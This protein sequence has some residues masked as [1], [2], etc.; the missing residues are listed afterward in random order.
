LTLRR[1]II[2]DVFLAAILL[3]VFILDA[4]NKREELQRFDR[5][6]VDFERSVAGRQTSLQNVATLLR[7]AV[8]PPP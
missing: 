5:A 7:A 6:C 3:A 2:V 8:I 4:E 1:R